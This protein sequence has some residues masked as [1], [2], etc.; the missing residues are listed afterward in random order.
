MRFELKG[1]S[2][3]PCLAHRS[4]LWAVDALRVQI[5][6]HA[7]YAFGVD[8]WG[9]NY[10]IKICIGFIIYKNEYFELGFHVWMGAA[11]R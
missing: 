4:R 10:I 5:L 1:D 2:V 7:A 6:C 11:I 3:D 8:V 9:V